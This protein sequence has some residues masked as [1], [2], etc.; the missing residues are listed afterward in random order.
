MPFTLSGRSLV[1]VF[2]IVL[3]AAIIGVLAMFALNL[4][5]WLIGHRKYASWAQ[6]LRFKKEDMQKTTDKVDKILGDTNGKKTK[7]AKKKA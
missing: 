5:Y 1:F 2:L 7:R 3:V 4:I 6:I